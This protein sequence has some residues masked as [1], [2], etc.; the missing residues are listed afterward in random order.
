MDITVE[1]FL[2]RLDAISRYKGRLYGR[3]FSLFVAEDLHFEKCIQ[4]KGYLKL[5]DAF[6]NFFLESIEYL[7][8][9]SMPKAFSSLSESYFIFIPG[10]IYNFKTLCGAERLALKGYPYQACTLLRNV[11][12]N[13]VLISAA[14][15]KFTDFASIEGI[16]AGKIYDPNANKK[17]RKKTEREIREKMTGKNSGLSQATCDELSKLDMLFDIE[18]HGGR[19]SQSEIHTWP[20][21]KKN[22]PI[23]PKFSERAFAMFMCRFIEIGWMFHRILPNIQPKIIPFNDTWKGKWKIIDE[24]YEVIEESMTKQLG[25]EIG[26]AFIEF[27]SKK[28]PYNQDSFFPL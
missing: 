26:K 7:N 19:M 18:V 22:L 27:I 17:L 13:L 4:Y 14:M 9:N 23:L 6:K 5:S 25:K 2:K 11:F 24:S 15:L 16:Q 10:F 12:D 3:V 28:F 8:K 20:E 21:N 1:E